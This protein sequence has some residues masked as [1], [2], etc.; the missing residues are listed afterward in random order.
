MVPTPKETSK[1]FDAMDKRRTQTA[2]V[3]AELRA[4]AFHGT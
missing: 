4:A 3:P 1:P 2:L